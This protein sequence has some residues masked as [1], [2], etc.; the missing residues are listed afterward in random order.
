MFRAPIGTIAIRVNPDVLNNDF[1]AV[2]SIFHEMFEIYKVKR[3][4]EENGPMAIR[5][6]RE[7]VKTSSKLDGGGEYH[8]AARALQGELEAWLLEQGTYKFIN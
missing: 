6:L 2:G 5:Q 4:F 3:L 7:F 8:R 1:L